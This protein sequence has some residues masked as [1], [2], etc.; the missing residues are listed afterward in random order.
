MG[1]TEWYLRWVAVRHY[2]LLFVTFLSLP[3]FS[4]PI[5]VVVHTYGF[6]GL[7]S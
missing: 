7:I 3:L 4:P 1:T 5:P 2:C 6:G